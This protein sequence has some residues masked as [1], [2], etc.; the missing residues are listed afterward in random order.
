[1]IGVLV[2][3]LFLLVQKLMKPFCDGNTSGNYGNHWGN[4]KDHD[5]II[6]F[7]FDV[8]DLSKDLHLTLNA[9]DMDFSDEMNLSLMVKPLI[10]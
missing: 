1:M 6:K 3:F 7:D 2:R 4:L 10:I 8:S 5:G 9:Y